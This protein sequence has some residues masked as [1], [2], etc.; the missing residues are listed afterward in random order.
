VLLAFGKDDALSEAFTS[1]C[2][3][4]GYEYNLGRSREAVLENFQRRCHEI[5]IVDI[6]NPKIFDGESICR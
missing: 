4:L 3:K 1:A 6:R 2:E 5:V